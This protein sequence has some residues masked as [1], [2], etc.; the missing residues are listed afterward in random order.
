M[1]T[2]KQHSSTFGEVSPGYSMGTPGVHRGRGGSGAAAA[3]YM[4]A[5]CPWGED[6]PSGEL[7]P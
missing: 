4:L 6:L 7:S 1:E 2:A 3:V 5:A